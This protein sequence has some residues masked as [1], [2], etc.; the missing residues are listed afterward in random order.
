MKFS[1]LLGKDKKLFQTRKTQQAAMR[2]VKDLMKTFPLITVVDQDD[3]V[4]FT[5]GKPHC[6]KQKVGTLIRERTAKKIA[7]KNISDIFNIELA[8]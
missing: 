2:V 5:Q 4:V 7:E 8:A 3:K 6:V 1:I